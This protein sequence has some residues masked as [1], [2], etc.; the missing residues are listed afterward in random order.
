MICPECKS[1]YRDGFTVCADCDIPL[2]AQPSTPPSARS[3]GQKAEPDESNF[4]D[5]QTTED[6]FC[7]FWEGEDLRICADICSVLDDAS[8]P[9]RVLRQEPHIF[10]IRADSHIK[11]GV[12]FSL[13]EKAE[14]SV[15]EA[16]GEAS[17]VR[18]LLWPSEQHRPPKERR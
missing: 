7:T 10:R 5:T 12:P 4:F 9:H 15:V 17:E 2:V 16:F 18:Q 1:E 3:S 14:A 6:P 13:F 8:I 11:I